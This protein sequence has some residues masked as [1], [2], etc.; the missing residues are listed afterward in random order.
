MLLCR[1]L[2]YNAK[3]ITMHLRVDSDEEN[4][5][6][7]YKVEWIIID[8]AG[9]TGKHTPPLPLSIIYYSI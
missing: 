5:N 8:P 2:T 3:E 6:K 1:S 9:F 4:P 7:S